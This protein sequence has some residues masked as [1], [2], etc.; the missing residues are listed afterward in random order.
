MKF[1]FPRGYDPNN[2]KFANDY[3]F[4]ETTYNAYIDVIESCVFHTKGELQGQPLILSDWQKEIIGA[5]FA[6]LHKTTKKRRYKEAFIYVPRKNGKSL[7][8]SALVI[9]YLLLDTEKGKEVVSVASAQDQASLIY[10][11]IRHSLRDSKSPVYQ[12][13]DPNFK[14]KVYSNPRKIVSENELNIYKPLTADGETNHGLNISFSI[15]DELHAWSE[16]SG[17]EVYE[18]VLTSSATRQSPLNIIITTADY[19]RDS[20]C[21][22][23]LEYAK[24]VASGK[25]DDPSFLPVLYYLDENEDYKDVKNWY[26]CNPQLGKSIP[27][28]FYKGEIQ[29]AENDP[30]YLNSFKRLYMNIQTKTENKFLDF[31]KWQNQIVRDLDLSNVR[32]FGGLDLA[33]KNDL[34]SFVLTFDFDDYIYVKSWFW[35]PEQH[36]DIK[37]YLD[38]GWIN[39]GY[40]KTTEGN[41]ID[42]KEL[43]LDL[44]EIIR[45]YN[46]VEIGYD[47]RFASELCSSLYNDEG[48]PM[49]EVPQYP[50]ILSEPLSDLAVRIESNKIKN[51]GND[52]ASWQVGNATAKEV[53]GGLIR[54]VKP[55]GKDST[56][57]K[58]DFVASLSMAHQRYLHDKITNAD[59]NQHVKKIF[60]SGASFF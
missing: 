46:I 9:A 23:K 14:F 44:I 30:T 25:V 8:C 54:L 56:L 19:L 38:R 5:L 57:L 10:E 2:S 35:I 1:N 47:P 58:V 59:L 31:T 11:P 18:A 48:F 21:N 4:C 53:G 15:M 12:L 3:Y 26:K 22:R 51:D 17:Q 24:A 41:A 55:V 39:D 13:D 40:I 60:E 42:F 20:I 49:V 6:T 32:A 27:E 29:K 34:V 7:F 45:Q 33:M 37:F 16:R 50:R 52:C 36:K 28:D 43:R